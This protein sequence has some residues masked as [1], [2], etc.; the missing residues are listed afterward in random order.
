MTSMCPGHAS[1]ADMS[2]F[3]GQAVIFH[4]DE[5]FL[6]EKRHTLRKAT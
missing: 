1:T 4:L 5:V 2:A 3:L 6:G